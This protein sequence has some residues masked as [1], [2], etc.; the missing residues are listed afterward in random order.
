MS[1]E[2][3]A[4]M[5]QQYPALSDLMLNIADNAGEFGDQRIGATVAQFVNDNDADYLRQA[6][7]ELDLACRSLPRSY[8]DLEDFMNYT[9][10][11]EEEALQTMRMMR[12]LIEKGIATKSARPG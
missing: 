11:S 12:D 4:F 3:F 5:N 10:K 8:Q 2:T 1:M 7:A 9:L 6:I